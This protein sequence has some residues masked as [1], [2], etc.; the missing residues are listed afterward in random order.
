MDVFGNIGK[1]GW[2][3]IKL[4]LKKLRKLSYDL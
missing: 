1:N 3:S 2:E 4:K